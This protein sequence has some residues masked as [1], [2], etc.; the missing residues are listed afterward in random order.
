MHVTQNFCSLHAARATLSRKSSLLILPLEQQ[1]TPF[2]SISIVWRATPHTGG[3][4]NPSS[5]CH[6][7]C[8]E[9]LVNRS[10]PRRDCSLPSHAQQHSAASV[11]Q[12]ACCSHGEWRTI[13]LTSQMLRNHSDTT[14]KSTLIRRM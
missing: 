2:P 10:P 4:R 6:T 11:V 8:Q 1:L 5:A 7:Y 12:A 14:Q 3:H 9:L 13:C